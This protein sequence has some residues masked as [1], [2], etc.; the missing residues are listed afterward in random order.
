MI[1]YRNGS[2]TAPI[3]EVDSGLVNY[4]YGNNIFVRDTYT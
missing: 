4:Y 1:Y 2:L 3:I